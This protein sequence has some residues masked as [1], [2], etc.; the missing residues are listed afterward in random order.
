MQT[1]RRVITA[2]DL[3]SLYEHMRGGLHANRIINAEEAFREGDYAQA[4]LL[5]QNIRDQYHGPTNLPAEV[6]AHA[7]QMYAKN[8]TTFLDHLT[9]DGSLALDREDEITRSTLLTH[10]GQ[11]V[12]DA[13]RERLASSGPEKGS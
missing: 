8:L 12:N 3:R 6:P 10:A 13:V 11:I 9:K 1:H 4:V 2:D 7:S 5:L